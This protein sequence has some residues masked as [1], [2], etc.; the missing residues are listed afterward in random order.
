[1]ANL[2]WAR[3]FGLAIERPGSVDFKFFEDKFEK[4]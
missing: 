4:K 2:T 3:A 1:M